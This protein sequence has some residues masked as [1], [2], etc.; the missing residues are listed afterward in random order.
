[1]AD[2]N[3]IVI[4]ILLWVFGQV[5]VAAGI[6]GAIRSDLKAMHQ[7]IGLTIRNT[8]KAHERIDGILTNGRGVYRRSS[9]EAYNG[10]R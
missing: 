6:W 2:A 1:M 5:V 4:E 8:D 7:L 9:D 3:Q 10:D